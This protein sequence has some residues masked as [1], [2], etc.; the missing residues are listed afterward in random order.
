MLVNKLIVKLAGKPLYNAD[1]LHKKIFIKNLLDFSDVYARGTAKSYLW[2][3][4][5]A[6]N[7]RTAA[8]GTN[9]GIKARGAL[10]YEGATVAALNPLKRYSFFKNLSDKLLPPVNLKSEIAELIW[11]DDG[12]DQ[13]IAAR[14]LKL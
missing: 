10:V 8:A 12:T 3:L 13:R 1:K 14:A 4:D 11:Q 6:N 7:T 9:A 5:T 2:Y